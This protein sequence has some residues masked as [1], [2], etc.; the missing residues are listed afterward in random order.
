MVTI[1]VDGRP[2]QVP[3]HTSASDIRRAAHTDRSRPVARSCDGRNVVVSGAIDVSEGDHFTLGRPFTK[4]MQKFKV[5]SSRKQRKSDRSVRLFFPMPQYERMREAFEASE[6]ASREG[7]AMARCGSR[8]DGS[9]K[10]KDYFVREL[11]IP[12]KDD[13]FQQSSVTV[14]PGA[15]FIEAVFSKASEKGDTVL[16]IHTHAG[17]REPNFSWMDIENG[18]ENGRFLRSCGLR[19]AMAV[20]GGAGF[21]FCEYDG[22]HDS[23]SMPESARVSVFSRNGLRDALVHKSSSSCEILSPTRPEA[24]RVAV[25][26][27]DGIGFGICQKLAG[28]GV[29]DFILLDDRELGDNNPDILPYTG[30]AGKKRT[31]AAQNMLKKASKDIRAVAVNNIARNARGALRECDVIF[32]CGK[33]D[34]LKSAIAEVSL[35]YLIPCIEAHTVIKEGQKGPYGSVRVLIPSITGCSMCSGESRE[36]S[37]SCVPVD[38]VVCSTAIGELM[39]MLSGRPRDSDHIEYDPA[40]QAFERKRLEWNEACPLCGREGVRGAGD[41]RRPRRY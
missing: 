24:I 23:L 26:G 6:A 41:E 3:V 32:Y 10:N 30:G 5:L 16:E 28:L 27:L 36:G 1:Y 34:A 7:Y 25:A 8:T 13:L 4:S 14:T 19:F 20:I 33:D 9:R 39:D 37:S 15:E 31:R 18:L 17:S 35:K 11:Y 12:A 21:S 40:T 22:D 38:D 29:K 2:V